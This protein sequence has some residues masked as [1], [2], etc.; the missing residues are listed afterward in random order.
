M[1]DDGYYFGYEGADCV[2][3]RDEGG[4]EKEVHRDKDA[5]WIGLM[6]MVDQGKGIHKVQELSFQMGF[7]EAI[8]RVLC[9]VELTKEQEDFVNE[10]ERAG[11]PDI[12]VYDRDF[13]WV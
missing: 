10:V 13:D 12:Q 7:R 11:T 4:T 2:L 1:M 6:V 8:E 5:L 3:Y 9:S